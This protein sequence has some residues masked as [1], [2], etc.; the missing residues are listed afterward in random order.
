MF[1]DV[2]V[3]RE[4]FFFGG[5]SDRPLQQF[6]VLGGDSTTAVFCVCFFVLSRIQAG[7][8]S[9][10]RSVRWAGNENLL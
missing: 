8:Y 2:L 3:L 7:H 6:C 10:L 1:Y 4:D 5:D 9:N